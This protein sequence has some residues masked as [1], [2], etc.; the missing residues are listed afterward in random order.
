[1]SQIDPRVLDEALG[2]DAQRVLG[3]YVGPGSAQ[4]LASVLEAHLGGVAVMYVQLADGR[5]MVTSMGELGRHG[6]RDP[7]YTIGGFDDVVDPGARFALFDD[8]SVELYSGGA[9]LHLGHDVDLVLV[10]AG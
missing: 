10:L 2:P 4:E 5:V 3:R 8:V 7:V 1:M 6:E 9:R